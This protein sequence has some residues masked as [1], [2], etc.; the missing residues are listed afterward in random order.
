MPFATVSTGM[1]LCHEVRGEGEPILLVMGL[2]RQ[3]V[4]WPEAFVDGLVE[5]GFKVIRFDNRDIGL[6]TKGKSK[7]PS[8]ARMVSG[9]LSRRF[10]KPEYLLSDMADDA[11][12]LLEALEIERA[13]IIG[14]SMGGMITQQLAIA[15]P[16][17]VLSI[18]SIMS[19]TGDRRV[20][21][22]KTSLGLKLAKLSK[23]GPE[24]YLDR[25]AEIFR[26][27]SGS[28]F[29]EKETRGVAARELARDYTPDGTV[30]QAAAILASPDRTPL[31]HTLNVP[32]LVVHGLED[33]LVTP[34]G[35]FATTKAIPGARLLAFPDMGHN[36]PQHRIPEI[37]D[38]I[39]ENMSRAA[40]RVA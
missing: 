6:S 37:L 15:H 5:R 4:A 23:G 40:T 22:A 29:D 21:R 13:H 27:V 26:L 3:L 7:P 35:G 34:S 1:T 36:L 39:V 30:R 33:T 18:T 11:A 12:G 25:Q 24:T 28:S 19:M 10:V 31:L 9:A 20:G 2:G 17:R 38:A 32:A 8:M 14:V 16:D